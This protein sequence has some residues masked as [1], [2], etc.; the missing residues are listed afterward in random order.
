MG[1]ALIFSLLLIVGLF[2]GAVV[3]III[4]AL[5]RK[6]KNIKLQT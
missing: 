2:V 6:M 1:N 4:T 5:K 3:V